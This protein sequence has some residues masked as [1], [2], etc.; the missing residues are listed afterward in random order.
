M[1]IFAAVGI[2]AHSAWV[3]LDHCQAWLQK[4]S[5]SSATGLE[6][7][8]DANIEKQFEVLKE[9]SDCSKF[10]FSAETYKYWQLLPYNPVMKQSLLFKIDSY[11]SNLKLVLVCGQA[12]ISTHRLQERSYCAIYSDLRVWNDFIIDW[13][14]LDDIGDWLLCRNG[15]DSIGVS[16]SFHASCFHYVNASCYH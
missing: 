12:E 7:I 11:E 9:A 4:S 3:S 10:L 15:T 1:A 2:Q 13:C 16:I 8:I 5:Y 6:S 14:A